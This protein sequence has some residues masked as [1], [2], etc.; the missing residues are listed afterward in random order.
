MGLR[1]RLLL[2]VFLPAIPGLFL[3]IYASLGQRQIG[4]ARVEKDAVRVVQLAAA[5][6]TVTKRVLA[7][8]RGAWH[9]PPP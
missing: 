6:Q 8:G 3:A 9:E 7:G 2:L 4:R 1:G 5:Q